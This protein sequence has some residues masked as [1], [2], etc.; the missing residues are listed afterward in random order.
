MASPSHIVT[1]LTNKVEI[2]ESEASMNVVMTILGCQSDTP[3]KKELKMKI[4]HHQTGL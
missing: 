4:C 3:V 1:E 2:G